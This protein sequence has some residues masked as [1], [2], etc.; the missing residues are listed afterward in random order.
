[1]KLL[2]A[3]NV[4]EDFEML[5]LL[6]EYAKKT[7]PDLSI[8]TGSV[9]KEV[10]PDEKTK[11]LMNHGVFQGSVMEL[12]QSGSPE[13]QRKARE[14]A[15]GGP[16]NP[17][18]HLKALA[19]GIL[20]DLGIKDAAV[21]NTARMVQKGFEMGLHTVNPRE[22]LKEAF[23]TMQA[24]YEKFAQ[25]LS[26]FPGAVYTLPGN[27]D[28]LPFFDILCEKNL[29]L[30]G[31]TCADMKIAGYGSSHFK[32]QHIPAGLLVPY[33]EQQLE[34]GLY[35]SEAVAFF[36]QQK[37]DI[38]VSY[39]PPDC[40]TSLPGTDQLKTDA[41]ED[42][43]TEREPALVLTG[44]ANNAVGASM[45]NASTVT[46]Y[47][48]SLGEAY[49]SRGGEFC[50]LD[51]EEKDLVCAD[52]YR[53]TDKAQGLAS[54]TLMKKYLRGEHGLDERPCVGGLLDKIKNP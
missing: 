32:P 4:F 36:L 12:L 6:C 17:Q 42:Y 50:V 41:L 38:V 53:I 43:L 10:L 2:Y 13:V 31:V 51:I 28:G 5:S 18:V 19:D 23:T 49:G 48:G 34:S 14:V 15:Q 46:I 24:Q 1:M 11:Q 40:K 27:F 44:L 33:V 45:H 3:A 16:F 26:A 39:T 37:P 22:L 52:F 9:T 29:H 35:L 21:R 8:V 25:A 54:A 30:K 20:V 7:S 47:P